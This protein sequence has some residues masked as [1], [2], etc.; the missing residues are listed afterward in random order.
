MAQ[1]TNVT[2]EEMGA[3]L[4]SK[5][6]SLLTLPGVVELVWAKLVR[7]NNVAVSMR[8]Y[9]GIDPSGDSRGVGEDAIRLELYWRDAN[10]TILRIGGSK[11]VHRVAGWRTNLQ[12]RID[13][14]QDMLGPTCP[15]CG[16]PMVLRK[17]KKE[18]PNKGREFYSCA[19]W[20]TT[21]CNGFQWADEA[22]SA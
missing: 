17:V 20:K 10:G 13:L 16:A 6:F 7:L 3:F 1:F 5:G 4:G 2:K 18:G 14:W 9:S 12:N 15:A 19:A 11:R 8:V 22:K 21:Q